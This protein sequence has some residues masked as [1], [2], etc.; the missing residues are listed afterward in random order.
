MNRSLVAA[1]GALLVIA[2]P[3]S[4]QLG[5]AA[6]AGTLGIGAEAALDLS[7]RL[8]VRGG[9]GLTA[10]DISTSFDGIDV[11]VELPGSW[12]NVGLD[13]YL[14]G[15][16]RLGAGIL[17]KPDDLRVTGVLDE[18]VDVGGRTFTPE[19]LGTLTGRLVSDDRAPYVLIG[20]GKHTAAGVGLFVDIGAAFT[21]ETEVTLDAEGGT[22]ADQAELQSRLDQEARDFEDD[23]KPYLRV[24][25]IFSLGL[26][27][28]FG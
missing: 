24:W 14:N 4:G 21:G 6:R 10:Y 26:R 11:E 22:F 12:Y 25:P 27:L 17:F 8:V 28:G 20:F 2:P 9:L 23:M 16:L 19:E 1:L 3:V 5:V 15:A 7:D 13:L 18:S